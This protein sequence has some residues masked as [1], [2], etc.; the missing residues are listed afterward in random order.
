M[1]HSNIFLF[2]DII[3]MF[4]RC[5]IK[6]ENLNLNSTKT[7][8][9]LSIPIFLE[10]ILQIL[11][12]NVDKIMV[13]NDFLANAITQANSIIDLLTIGSYI[14]GV[15]FKMGIIGVWGA[16]TIDELVRALIFII[17]FKKEKWAKIDLIEC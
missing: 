7:L 12:V 11:L 13:R 4:F 15:T 9:K 16:M 5:F 10:L 1:L 2:C 6:I 14:F 8:I 17:R 3:C